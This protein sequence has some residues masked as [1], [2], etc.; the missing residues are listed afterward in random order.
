MIGCS[1][2]RGR[3]VTRC[4]RF[5]A[6]QQRPKIRVGLLAAEDWHRNPWLCS[7]PG[8][9]TRLKVALRVAIDHPALTRSL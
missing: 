9:E 1:I 5:T 4:M 6:M 8:W 2:P 3:R 7:L